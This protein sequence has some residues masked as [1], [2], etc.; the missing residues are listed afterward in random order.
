MIGILALIFLLASYLAYRHLTN[1]F[2]GF[3]HFKVGWNDLY[4][5]PR[6][7]AGMEGPEKASPG[8]RVE[9]LSFPLGNAT[10]TVG[11]DNGA[12]DDPTFVVQQVSGPDSK[13]SRTAPLP[14]EHMYVTAE[15]EFHIENRINQCFLHKRKYEFQ[16]EE[17]SELVQPFYLINRNTRVSSD[18]SMYEQKGNQGRVIAKVPKGGT[19]R[20]LLRENSFER[21]NYLVATEHGLVGWVVSTCGSYRRNSGPLDL[22]SLIPEPG[23]PLRILVFEGD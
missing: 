11:F 10:C 3:V 19:V 6:I 21:D 23:D 16:G 8:K 15:G 22:G 12:S 14:G 4:L 18:L 2:R 1:P 5:D 17:F 9:F 20:V 13:R 7:V